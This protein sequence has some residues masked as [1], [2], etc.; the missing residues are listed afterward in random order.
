MPVRAN[1]SACTAPRRLI[2]C[3]V[4]KPPPR[5]PVGVLTASTITTSRTW[6]SSLQGLDKGYGKFSARCAADPL[7]DTR[8][9][10]VRWRRRLACRRI[11]PHQ[12]ARC[13]GVEHVG[14]VPQIPFH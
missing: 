11:R 6:V 12:Y 3:T 5:R 2:E 1:S 10:A 9:Q 8:K 4:D 14:H 7:Q 13:E